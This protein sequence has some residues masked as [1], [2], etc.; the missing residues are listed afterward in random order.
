MGLMPEPDAPRQ[1]RHRG[2]GR[3]L[4]RHARDRTLGADRDGDVRAVD[5]APR[6]PARSGD[7][8][9]RRSA[10]HGPLLRGGPGARPAARPGVAGAASRPARRSWSRSRSLF[11]PNHVGRTR[12]AGDERTPANAARLDAWTASVSPTCREP[13]PRER[14]AP[15]T[16]RR[17][18]APRS[19]APSPRGC[20]R[21]P[22]GRPSRRASASACKLWEATSRRARTSSSSTESRTCL[23]RLH[24]AGQRPRR[25]GRRADL[26]AAGGD[27]RPP[28]RAAARRVRRRGISRAAHA[29]HVDLG[30][31]RDARR[32]G[33]E[34]RAHGPHAT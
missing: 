20:S 18:R 17:A 28:P 1:R 24:S 26:D 12:A 22:T 2:A 15:A 19:T 10:G 4:H 29:A 6:E 9:P 32:R 30:L 8:R 23:P 14:A 31:P 5:R 7:R 33:G 21:S 13:R 27:G 16:S 25:H 11:P 3:H 34:P